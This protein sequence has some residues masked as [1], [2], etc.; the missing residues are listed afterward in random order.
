MTSKHSYTHSSQFVSKHWFLPAL[1]HTAH[2]APC[3][4]ALRPYASV[5][6]ACNPSGE[7][8]ILFH[9]RKEH[10]LAVPTHASDAVHP[11][12]FARFRQSHLGRR[13]PVRVV[14]EIH[15]TQ[16]RSH[17]VVLSLS[18][19]HIP[20]GWRHEGMGTCLRQFTGHVGTDRR[21]MCKSAFY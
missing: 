6:A 7:N 8:T 13:V 18:G 9:S 10:L 12:A 5:I 1:Y 11:H 16:I 19:T 4:C 17:G 20:M 3:V 15:A 2:T 14:V 21:R